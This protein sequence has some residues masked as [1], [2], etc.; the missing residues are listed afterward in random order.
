MPVA[1]CQAGAGAGAAS[2]VAEHSAAQQSPPSLV[3]ES[4]GSD[5]TSTPSAVDV[6]LPSAADLRVPTAEELP[7]LIAVCVQHHGTRTVVAQ[8]LKVCPAAK[9]RELCDQ[10]WGVRSDDEDEHF[11]RV[12]RATTHP[13]SH[14]HPPTHIPAGGYWRGQRPHT[15]DCAAP[16]FNARR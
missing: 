1:V 5:A 14:S 15:T 3:T 11:A 4:D 6:G 9:L 16:R 13:A 12:R 2:T 8:L 10:A 7:G